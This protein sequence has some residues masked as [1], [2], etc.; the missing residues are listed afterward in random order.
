VQGVSDVILHGSAAE[1]RGPGGG[2]NDPNF[3]RPGPWL[4][5]IM[6][7]VKT[8][9]TSCKR[10]FDNNIQTKKFVND[11]EFINTAASYSTQI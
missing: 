6:S 2:S 1:P 5:V 4:L 3:C 11:R 7:Y 10:E 8:F 9:E